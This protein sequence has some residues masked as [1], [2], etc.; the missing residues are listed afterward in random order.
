MNVE[1]E[2]CS[3]YEQL[4]QGMVTKDIA[5]LQIILADDFVLVHM[6]G[7]Q[8]SKDEFIRSIQNGQLQY[9]SAETERLQVIERTLDFAVLLGQ[10]HVQAAVF[11]G[12][13]HLWRLQLTLWMTKSNGAWKFTKAIASVF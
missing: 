8:Q 2:F 13:K 7:M 5:L 9:C 6:T 3:C 11:G 4:Y 10:S 1:Q 12:G